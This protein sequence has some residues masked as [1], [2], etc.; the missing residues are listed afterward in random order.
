VGGG[1]FHSLNTTL[2]LLP[3]QLFPLLHF[4]PERGD[5]ARSLQ[6]RRDAQCIVG[7]I[8]GRDLESLL[9][10]FAARAVFNSDVFTCVLIFVFYLFMLVGL[11]RIHT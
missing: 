8:T 10:T 5:M 4:V 9:F 7:E 6:H 2:L 1:G 3:A 11:V